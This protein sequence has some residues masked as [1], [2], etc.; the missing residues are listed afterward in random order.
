[1]KKRIAKPNTNQDLMEDLIQMRNELEH[2]LIFKE[3]TLKFNLEMISLIRIQLLDITTQIYE[4]EDKMNN[5]NDYFK[6]CS[7]IKKR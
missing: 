3:K 6:F 7:R 4:L 2:S 1:M 5:A